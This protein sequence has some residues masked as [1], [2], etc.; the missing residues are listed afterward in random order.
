MSSEPI[1]VWLDRLRVGDSHALEQV[2]PLV[3]D[4]LRAAARRQL[5]AEG[6]AHTLTPTALVHEAYL[7]LLQ[8]RSIDAEHRADFLGIAARTMRRVLVDHA[9]R[10]LAAKRGRGEIH[11]PVD[12]VDLPMTEGEAEEMLSLEA[13]L[14]RLAALDERAARVVELRFFGGLSVEEAAQMLQVSTKTVQRTWVAARAWLRKEV[15]A[16]LGMPE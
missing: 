9:R 3:Y 15:A 8:Q 7:R 4:E 6:R 13:A 5:R 16:G 14:G 12:D 1:T 10:R 11:V 2:L